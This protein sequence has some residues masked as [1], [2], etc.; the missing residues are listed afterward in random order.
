LLLVR[1]KFRG[2]SLALGT[3]PN[4]YRLPVLVKTA[5]PPHSRL[6]VVGVGLSVSAAKQDEL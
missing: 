5:F 4:L 2:E 6:S 1:L 3:A